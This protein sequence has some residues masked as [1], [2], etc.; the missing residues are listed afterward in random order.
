MEMNPPTLEA[1]ERRAASRGLLLHC[2]AET[3]SRQ[4]VFATPTP[5][6]TETWYPLPHRDLVTEVEGQLESAGFT[7]Q[8]ESHALSHG[9]DR[10]F[11]VFEV[12][13]PDRPEQEHNWIVGIR[14]S[15]D[16][17]YPAGLVAGS[18]VLCCDNLA[19]CGEVR[20]SRKHTRFAVRDL[21]HLTARAVG[22]LGDRFRKLDERIA[23]YQERRLTDPKAHDLIIQAIDC[24]AITPTQVPKVLAEWRKPSH[25]EFRPRTAWSLFN[26]FTESHKGLN[27]NAVVARS[28]AL[29]GLFDGL[30]GLN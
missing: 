10:Y 28:Q 20:I 15:H 21:R 3:V 1:P 22:Q 5:G 11:G 6:A 12:G 25:E 19:F 4:S 8:A 18:S 23:S 27:P 26:A 2:G 17:T 7:L 16:K 14:N 29:H 24:R 9:G 13:L 30:V